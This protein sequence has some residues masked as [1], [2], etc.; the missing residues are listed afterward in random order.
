MDIGGRSKE[1]EINSKPPKFS[2]GNFSTL[3]FR[4]SGFGCIKYLTPTLL[5]WR[6]LLYCDNKLCSEKFNK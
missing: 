6:F 5:S 2:W 1:L 3:C 4:Y